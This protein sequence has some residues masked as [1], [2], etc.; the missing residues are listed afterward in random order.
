MAF[1]FATAPPQPTLLEAKAKVG[2]VKE[3][4]AAAAEADPTIADVTPGSAP[5]PTTASA[6]LEH[7]LPAGGLT[8]P[9]VTR[10]HGGYGTQDTALVGADPFVAVPGLQT[11]AGVAAYINGVVARDPRAL[12]AVGAVVGMAVA[13]AVGH[14]L[15][16]L[17]VVDTPRV[18][19]AKR[20]FPFAFYLCKPDWGLFTRPSL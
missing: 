18:K 1:R 10:G 14:P 2:S 13:D 11:K 20:P 6:I 4:A 17:P 16:F 3:E 7:A 9:E 8:T 19:G 5:A 12:K 15:E